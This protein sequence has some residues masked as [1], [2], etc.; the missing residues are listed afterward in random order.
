VDSSNKKG[1]DKG[2]D[3]RLSSDEANSKFA[4]TK[5]VLLS[6][7]S[8]KTSVAHVRDLRGTV[9][10]EGAAIGVLLTLQD[11]TG[12]MRAEAA[13]AGFC[14]AKAWGTKHAKMQVLSIAELLDDGW[15]GLSPRS[16]GS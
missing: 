13:S 16:P 4:S 11:P 12:P 3:G 10:R 1:A 6:V 8:G 2:V 14:E 5:N 15:L 9:E 7:K